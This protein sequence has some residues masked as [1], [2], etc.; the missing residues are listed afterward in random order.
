MLL[1]RVCPEVIVILG[2]PEVSHE[3]DQQE[4]VRH[5]DYLIIGEAD[6]KFAELCRELLGGRRPTARIIRPPLPELAQ[7]TLPYAL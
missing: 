4:I 2:G 6:L 5:A 1:K 3:W 7:L